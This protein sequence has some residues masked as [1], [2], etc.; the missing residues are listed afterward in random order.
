MFFQMYI[1]TVVISFLSFSFLTYKIR[2]NPKDINLSKLVDGVYKEFNNMIDDVKTEKEKEELNNA[3]NKVNSYNV[4]ILIFFICL[5]PVFN[6][7]F[8][9]YLLKFIKKNG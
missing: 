3:I 1:T 2:N 6:L 5:L 8:V 7:L 4:Y 9:L